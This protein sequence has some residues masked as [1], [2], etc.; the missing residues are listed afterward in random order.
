[1][2]FFQV[3]KRAFSISLLII[4]LF[5]CFGYRLLLSLMEDQAD[6]QLEAQLDENNYDPSQLISV[7]VPV[8]YLPYYNNS[9]EFERVDGQVEIQGVPYK[10]VKRRIFNDSLEL[11]CIP[12]GTAL[13][14][15]KAGSEF[16]KF[17]ND[18]K[19]G[20]KSEPRSG[21]MKIFSID[22]CTTDHAYRLK[23]PD[24][25]LSRQSS[26]YC[27]FIPSRYALT[28]DHPPEYNSYCSR[29]LSR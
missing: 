26:A 19:P 9:E 17:T 27:M 25:T 24:H 13:K 6:K 28:A 12:N 20:K 18:L 8:T 10:Y 15:Q 2:L 7:K 23:A 14:F 1:V 5:N 11:L 21:S 22:Y 29:E 4:L 16:F 3:L